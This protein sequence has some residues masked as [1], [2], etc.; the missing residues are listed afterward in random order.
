M[1]AQVRLRRQAA[2]PTRARFS[3][4]SSSRGSVGNA[5]DEEHALD[6]DESALATAPTSVDGRDAGAPGEREHRADDEDLPVDVGRH[7]LRRHHGNVAAGRHVTDVVRR[8]SCN[9]GYSS[10]NG[11]SLLDV[12]VGGC[13]RRSASSRPSSRRSLTDR[14]RTTVHLT[15]G[16][17]TAHVNG[18][19]GGGAL[20][21]LPRRGDL[22]ERLP[23]HGAT[24]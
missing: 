9:E 4:A 1:N 10:A 17:G 21:G 22:L 11:N 23:V 16:T 6:G 18:C 12:I 15:M 5:D 24:A 7:D 2:R 14:R 13:T 20:S 3:S 19:T 8:S